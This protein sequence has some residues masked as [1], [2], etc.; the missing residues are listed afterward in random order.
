[1]RHPEILALVLASA[2]LAA[3]PAGAQSIIQIE[4]VTPGASGPTGGVT[5]TPDL[6]TAVGPADIL[7]LSTGHVSVIAL[8]NT[9]APTQQTTEQFWTAAGITGTPN[10][11]EHRAVYDN[12][13]GHFFVT[14]DEHVAGANRRYLAVSEGQTAAGPW[15][16]VVIPA[17]GVITDT[18]LAV[19]ANG[20]Y[21][22]GNTGSG[23]TAI[24]SIP[25]PYA[26]AVP[27]TH[28]HDNALAIPE[29]D[30]IPA[31]YAAGGKAT[32]DPEWFAARGVA[33]NGNTAIRMYALQWHLGEP[34]TLGSVQI[35]DLGAI[36]AL[37]PATATEP[38]VVQLDASDASL[39]SLTSLGPTLYGI[40][41]TTIYGQAGAFAFSIGTGGGAIQSMPV[42]VAGA[43][44]ITPAL[45]VDGNG[46]I[47]VIGVI[48]SS[49]IAPT[50]AV[51]G[52]SA[53]GAMNSWPT[54]IPV[55]A[56]QL[57]YTCGTGSSATPFGRYSS[58]VVAPTGTTGI[59]FYGDAMYGSDSA[60]GYQTA[61]VAFDTEILAYG[62]DFPP[63]D[64]IGAEWPIDP[65]DQSHFL[66]GCC[67]AS[68]DPT[69]SLALVGCCR[70]ALLRRRRARRC[71]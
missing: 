3:T 62:D 19:D 25:L 22:T 33:G 6:A 17:A 12:A 59:Q 42:G 8:Y 9:T 16:A 54:P 31:I 20:A 46:D 50:V 63:A 7:D 28:V 60:C 41:A 44:F 27:Q 5:T 39:R 43:D 67:S 34:A 35:Q 36:Y 70:L 13:S 49:A 58:L 29:P 38:G 24:V 4:G 1:M 68:G 55:T 71:R 18:R 30:A 52:Q 69:S 53:Q 37:P 32:T 47:G 64:P 21:I 65:G 14:A 11:F 2:A 26:L 61:I 23:A 48:T 51:T 45:A 10:A 40:A 15:H 66:D 56:S 57:P